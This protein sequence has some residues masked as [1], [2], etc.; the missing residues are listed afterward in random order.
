MQCNDN[1]GLVMSNDEISVL[2]LL[3]FGGAKAGLVN[4]KSGTRLN[5][6]V[7][8]EGVPLSNIRWGSGEVR[9]HSAGHFLFLK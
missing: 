5:G 3:T 6:G 2:K 8:W 9:S 1:R 7:V 4:S